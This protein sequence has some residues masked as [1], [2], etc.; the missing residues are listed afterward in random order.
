MTTKR[1]TTIHR[2]GER[3]LR[4]ERVFNASPRIVFTAYTR[5]DL[6]RQWWTPQSF[7][8]M[9][10]C[11]ADVRPG[12]TYRYVTKTEHGEAAFSG[13]YTEVS[14]YTRVAFTQT[15]EPM[16]HAGHAEVVV[17]FEDLGTQTR[18]VSVETYPSKEALE[19]AFSSGMEHGVRET[20]DQLDA[21]VGKMS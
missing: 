6:V 11:R 8:E 17:T 20:F 1:E 13:H 12:G 19:M 2:T 5:D 9:L 4:I 15:F 7:T 21:L 18:L 10:E 14:P 16:A 3:Q